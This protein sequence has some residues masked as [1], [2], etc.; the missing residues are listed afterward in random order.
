MTWVSMAPEVRRKSPDPEAVRRHDTIAG[1][2]GER[3]R[4]GGGAR[5]S[6]GK[7]ELGGF[8]GL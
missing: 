2:E 4:Q 6:G 8:A 3:K 5:G 1:V 7:L